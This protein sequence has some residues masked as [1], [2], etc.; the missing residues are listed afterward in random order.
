MWPGRAKTLTFLGKAMAS[1][2]GNRNGIPEALRPKAEHWENVW[3][4]PGLAGSVT[5]EFSPALPHLPGA[6]LA[7][8]E[9]DSAGGPP[10][11]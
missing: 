9:P 8:T 10:G 11:A 1:R 3:G 6:V 2:R 5:V 4:L 7:G